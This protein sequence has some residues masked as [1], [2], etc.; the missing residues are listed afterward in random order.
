MAYDPVEIDR[1]LLAEV[2]N[3]TQ[4]VAESVT[5]AVRRA[6]DDHAF[7]QLLDDLES[8]SGPIPTEIVAEVERFWHAF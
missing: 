4:D 3:L 8:Q 5:A 6:L 7:Q 1:E 2:K